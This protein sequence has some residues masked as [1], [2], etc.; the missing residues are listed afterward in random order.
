M[1]SEFEV[2]LLVAVNCVGAQLWDLKLHSR[3]LTTKEQAQG[4]FC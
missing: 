1:S 4:R 3:A 2:S